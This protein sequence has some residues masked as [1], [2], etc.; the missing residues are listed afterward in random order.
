[1]DVY[2]TSFMVLNISIF[3]HTLWDKYYYLSLK[4][5]NLR[6]KEV[7]YPAQEHSL[8]YILQIIRH[9]LFSCLTSLKSEFPYNQ[10]FLTITGNQAAVQCNSDYVHLCGLGHSCVSSIDSTVVTYIELKLLFKMSSSVFYDLELK[11]IVYTKRNKAVDHKSYIGEANIYC[12]RNNSNFIFSNKTTTK[13]FMEVGKRTG[14]INNS[15]CSFLFLLL[16]SC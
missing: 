3:T 8:H 15:S 7:K 4:I 2:Y 13:S 11:V 16:F 12:F 1:M 10:W 5:R 6:H 14:S 9:T